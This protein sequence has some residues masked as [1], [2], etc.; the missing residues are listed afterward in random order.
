MYSGVWKVWEC[1][2]ITVKV[3]LFS[4]K[5]IYQSYFNS[6]CTAYIFKRLL[7][8][9]IYCVYSFLGLFSFWIILYIRIWG[10]GWH[11]QNLMSMCF[12][13]PSVQRVIWS[14]PLIHFNWWPRNSAGLFLFV[15]QNVDSQT[16][17]GRCISH[18]SAQPNSFTIIKPSAFRA[19]AG[20]LGVM[21]LHRDT[22]I[23]LSGLRMRLC[24][25]LLSLKTS[26]YS[27]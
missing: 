8:M 25:R 13:G 5:Y 20:N 26:K 9:H 21:S 27:S 7:K 1:F 14:M 16:F 18:D 17:G 15:S 6:F 10:K 24:N 2:Y 3:L 12:D 11:E 4:R 23:P 19:N 22:A